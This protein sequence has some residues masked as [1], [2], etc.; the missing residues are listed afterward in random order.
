MPRLQHR[1]E[2]GSAETSPLWAA[3]P[4]TQSPAQS[5]EVGTTT[6]SRTGLGALTRGCVRY[7]GGF[8]SNK[9]TSPPLEGLS[10]APRRVMQFPHT[11]LLELFQGSLHPQWERCPAQPEPA[12]AQ[13]HPCTSL[14]TPLTHQPCSLGPKGLLGAVQFYPD[15]QEASVPSKGSPATSRKLRRCV[16]TPVNK[17]IPVAQTPRPTNGLPWR[18]MPI[19]SRFQV[20]CPL[21]SLAQSSRIMTVCFV[22]EKGAWGVGVLGASPRSTSPTLCLGAA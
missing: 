7:S 5:R 9:I 8:A 19:R 18:S 20:T 21:L 3:G 11:L 14:W 17:N 15:L 12:G 16:E 4:W 10:H 13:H 1:Q 6:G 2:T 22:L